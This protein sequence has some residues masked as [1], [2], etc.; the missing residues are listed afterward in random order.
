M[1]IGVFGYR[2]KQKGRKET[3]CEMKMCSDDK[4]TKDKAAQAAC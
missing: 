3:K 1:T 2:G 4:A